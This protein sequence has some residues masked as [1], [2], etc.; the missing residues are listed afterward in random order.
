MFKYNGKC[1]VHTVSQCSGQRLLAPTVCQ[2]PALPAQPAALG[3]P[4]QGARGRR[5]SSGGH[6]QGVPH[7]RPRTHTLRVCPL[8]APL[9]SPF[10]PCATGLGTGP[11]AVRAKG[12]WSRP[13]APLPRPQGRAEPSHPATRP[14]GAQR[15]ASAHPSLGHAASSGSPPGTPRGGQR[16]QVT[17]NS[18]CLQLGRANPASLAGPGGHR[19]QDAQ[20]GGAPARS[21][22]TRTPAG[23]SAP[24]RRWPRAP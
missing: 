15:S 8:G 11:G 6:H 14:Y 2:A 13:N 24:G 21:A 5:P 18:F 23:T 3:E 9:A 19:A 17:G 12:L 4:A 16:G 1:P 10:Q 20:A 7:P 22:Q